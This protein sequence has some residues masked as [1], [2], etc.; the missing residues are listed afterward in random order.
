MTEDLVCPL[1]L[2]REIKSSFTNLKRVFFECGVCQLL[3][4][5]SQYHLE[6]EAEKK[7][8]ETHQN[9]VFDPGYQ[10]FVMPLFEVIR[11]K[12][13]LDRLGLDFGAGTGPVLTKLLRD[14]GFQIDLY[15]PYFHPFWENLE[16]S[17]DFVFASEVVEHFY[18]PRTDF[19]LLEK[20]VSPKGCLFVMTLLYQEDTVKE[21]WFYLKDPTHVCAYSLGTF[22]WIKKQF[23]F[24][25]LE[26]QGSR[27]VILTK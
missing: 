15:D 4:V 27:V 24:S 11:K 17:Y 18:H 13:S 5:D 23:G 10:K 26:T 1:C 20:I 21:N 7:R 16:K 9:D 6:P 2:Q 8:Y 14:A 12:M 22:E 19:N 25:D 3:F